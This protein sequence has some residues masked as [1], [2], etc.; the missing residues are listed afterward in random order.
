MGML[1]ADMNPGM[2]NRYAYVFN[3]PINGADSTGMICDEGI[4][5]AVRTAIRNALPG[6]DNAQELV[7]KYGQ[8]VSDIGQT[9][10]SGQS[11]SSGE[12]QV[13]GALTGALGT[14]SAGRVGP[15]TTAAPAAT[16]SVTATTP[17]PTITQPYARPSNATT[18][19]QRAAVQGKPCTECGATS[20]TQ[21]ANHTPP[22]V[23]EY[24]STGTINTTRM[25]STKAVTPHCPTCSN[26]EG[27]RMS[28][29]SKAMKK[30]H[31]FE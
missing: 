30:A 4:C 25:R 7:E 26:A 23:K 18:P 5:G 11:I 13:V 9:M 28:A 21:R 16:R 20:A 31:G 29:F 3:D 24:Y 27:G 22:L 6:P 8:P 2:F 15:N 12:M 10:P 14:A 17:K 1:D 19:A